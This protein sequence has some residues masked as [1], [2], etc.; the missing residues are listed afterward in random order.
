MWCASAPGLR[1]RDGICRDGA[2]HQSLGVDPVITPAYHRVKQHASRYQRSGPSSHLSP[3]WRRPNLPSHNC[4]LASAASEGRGR[5]FE[6]HRVHHLGT[7][8]RTSGRPASRYQIVRNPAILLSVAA[9]P[10]APK[11]SRRPVTTFWPLGEAG[12]PRSSTPPPAGDDP[13]PAEPRRLGGDHPDP[14]RLGPP[15]KPLQ[16]SFAI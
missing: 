13:A 1:G 5:E 7:W 3:V 11:R 12:R 4:D 9:T 16:F 14:C 15:L 10:S 6:S 8:T 2:L